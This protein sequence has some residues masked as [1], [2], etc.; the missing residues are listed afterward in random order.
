MSRLIGILILAI[1]LFPTSS[2]AQARVLFRGWAEPAGTCGG[3]VL[4][5]GKVRPTI[6]SGLFRTN[7]KKVSLVRNYS[8]SRSIVDPAWDQ[9]RQI[10]SL[11][12]PVPLSVWNG[13]HRSLVTSCGT[14]RTTKEALPKTSVGLGTNAVHVDDKIIFGLG[15]KKSVAIYQLRGNKASELARIPSSAHS[16]GELA[17]VA[18]YRTSKGV[19][20]TAYDS[21]API[22]QLWQLSESGPRIIGVFDELIAEGY[23]DIEVGEVTE[24]GAGRIIF[25]VGSTT[26]WGGYYRHLYYSDGEQITRVIALPLG[27]NLLEF[28]PVKSQ[29]GA[30]VYFRNTETSPASCRLALIDFRDGS[31]R[32]MTENVG[33]LSR[34]E[35]LCADL[36]SART[37]DGS[38]FF[39]LPEA[40]NNLKR[41][42]LSTGELSELINTDD[43][44][45]GFHALDGR[46]YF[47]VKEGSQTSKLYV[48]DGTPSGTQPIRVGTRPLLGV[49]MSG[50]VSL[51]ESLFVA[52]YSRL[53]G[54]SI[55]DYGLYTF[56]PPVGRIQEY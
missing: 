11:N 51:N 19:V 28:F 14:A 6:H 54:D 24:N 37:S 55:L 20:F 36:A 23:T 8:S 25:S 1:A 48:S 42:N 39:T 33:D 30:L 32:D 41:L 26:S 4:F 40:P 52:G 45:F 18:L 31:V 44:I 3:A 29:D 2:S 10:P 13:K 7:G 22:R 49:E 21:S 46:M 47:L 9:I 16:P 35:N 50:S 34:P 12:Q 38:L 17:P 56:V 15:G 53:R 5:T 43:N 27:A